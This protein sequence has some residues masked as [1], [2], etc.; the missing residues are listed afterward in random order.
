MTN[1]Q[2]M[3]VKGLEKGALFLAVGCVQDTGA[4]QMR[5]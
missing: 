4:E 5:K 3:A 1:F 2:Q